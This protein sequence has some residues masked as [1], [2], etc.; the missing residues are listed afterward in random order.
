[1]RRCKV[2]GVDD[3]FRL[4]KKTE[5]AVNHRQ[6]TER[7]EQKQKRGHLDHFVIRVFQPNLDTG[8]PE[9]LNAEKE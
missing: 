8:F 9:L 3:L 7:G 2:N 4:A 6:R 5:V 1:M